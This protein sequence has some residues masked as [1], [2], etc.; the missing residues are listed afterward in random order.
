VIEHH[1][2]GGRERELGQPAKALLRE[3]E[4]PRVVLQAPV[5]H[6]VDG[7]LVLDEDTIHAVR[8][9]L[10]IPSRALHVYLGDLLDLV[11]HPRSMW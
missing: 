4:L 9:P 6:G 7:V 3:Q 11:A 2:L 1:P 10:G 5:Q 8:N